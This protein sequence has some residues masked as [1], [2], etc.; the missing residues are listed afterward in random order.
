M[1]FLSKKENQKENHT[2]AH[3]AKP[4]LKLYPGEDI[5]LLFPTE[6]N[7]YIHSTIMSLASMPR[8]YNLESKGRQYQRIR[9]YFHALDCTTTAPSPRPQFGPPPTTHAPMKT[10]LGTQH[11][12]RKTAPSHI[13]RLQALKHTIILSKQT[14]NSHQMPPS[15]IPR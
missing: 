9:Q 12:I 15:H 10:P 7:I 1:Y 8:S 4:L 3:K 13:P 6:P 5:L 14:A 2:K 11:S